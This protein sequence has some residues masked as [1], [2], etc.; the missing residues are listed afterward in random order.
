M[1]LMMILEK[2]NNGELPLD[3]QPNIN[4]FQNGVTLN[5]HVSIADD[6]DETVDVEGII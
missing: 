6:T 1:Y 5:Q 2:I 4:K 3:T